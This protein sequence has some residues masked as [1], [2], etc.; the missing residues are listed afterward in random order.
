MKRF[1]LI[2]TTVGAFALLS[3][4]AMAADNY[5]YFGRSH[6]AVH[7]GQDHAAL[8]HRAADRAAVHHNSHHYPTARYQHARTHARLNHQAA[9][10]AA[11]HHAAHDRHAYSPFISYGH[12]GHGYTGFRFRAPHVSVL[13]GH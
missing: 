9:H 12:G 8:N 2:V 7:H 5:Y 4:P 6:G 3:T 10:D 11:R 13:L 1:A